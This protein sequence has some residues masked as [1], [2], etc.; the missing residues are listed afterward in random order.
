ML[1]KLLLIFILLFPFSVSADSAI[2]VIKDY[3]F[4]TDQS[5][6]L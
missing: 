3:D 2:D 1:K 5:T 4:N 6:I